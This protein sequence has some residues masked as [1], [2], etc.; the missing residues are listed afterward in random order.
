MSEA[1]RARRGGGLHTVRD[2][3]ILNEVK[4]LGPPPRIPT[5]ASLGLDPPLPDDLAL[6]DAGMKHLDRRGVFDGK[7]ICIF[8][9]LIFN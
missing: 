6:L 7:I 3:V 8:N 4:E 2:S 9:M 1:N 5:L